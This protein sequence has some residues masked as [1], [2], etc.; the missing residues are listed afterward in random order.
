MII[1]VN[2]AEVLSSPLPDVLQRTR[3]VSFPLS[4]SP[5]S[6]RRC[7]GREERAG[8]CGKYRN[9]PEAFVAIYTRS[10]RS[11]CSCPVFGAQCP[12]QRI[13]SSDKCK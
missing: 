7:H 10:S 11:P 8:G 12:A 5:N 13:L 4:G 2:T 3:R 1:G 9:P 6:P